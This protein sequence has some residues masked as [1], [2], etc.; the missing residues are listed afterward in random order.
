MIKNVIVK[1]KLVV[2]MNILLFVLIIATAILLIWLNNEKNNKTISEVEEVSMQA[3]VDTST[4]DTNSVTIIKDT[5][6]GYEIDVPIPKGYVMSNVTGETEVKTGLVIYE[7]EEAVTD[8]NKEESQ[9]TRNQWVWVPVEPSEMYGTDENG[10]NRENYMT[11]V[12]L[13]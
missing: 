11:L 13:E 7:G 4:W 9:K 8:S 3:S 5:S 12:V 1:T 2:G 10:K 6:M